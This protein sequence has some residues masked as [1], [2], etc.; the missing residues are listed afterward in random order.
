VLCWLMGGAQVVG[1]S[2]GCRFGMILSE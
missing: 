2:M 1:E